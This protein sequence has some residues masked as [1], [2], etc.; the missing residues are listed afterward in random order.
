MLTWEL[1]YVL[2]PDADIHLT[3]QKFNKV[4][5]IHAKEQLA[6]NFK[7]YGYDPQISY[8]LQPMTDIHLNPLSGQMVMRKAVL[9]MAVVLFTPICLWALR[10]LFY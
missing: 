10:C 4:Y 1:L 9:L 3:E 2:H 6:A 8:G 5:A 7:T